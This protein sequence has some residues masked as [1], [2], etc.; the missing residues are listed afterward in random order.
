MQLNLSSM[1]IRILTI[2]NYPD[3]QMMQ[4]KKFAFQ[5]ETF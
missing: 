1:G 2:S 3:L 5:V 4:S